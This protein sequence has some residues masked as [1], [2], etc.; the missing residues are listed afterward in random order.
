MAM[1]DKFKNYR[2]AA[3][4]I[5]IC[6]ANAYEEKYFFN[7]KFKDIPN[8]IQEDLRTI[9]ILFTQ[10]VGGIF[11]ICYDDNGEVLL[12]TEAAEDDITYDEVSSGLLIG[13]IRQNRRELFESLRL[14]FKVMILKEDPAKVLAEAGEEE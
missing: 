4:H 6:G 12:Q 11:T 14:Y 13:Q 1:S 9:T 3:G 2:D 7:D 5:V 8:S 10:E